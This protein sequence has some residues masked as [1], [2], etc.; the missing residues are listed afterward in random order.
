MIS[1]IVMVSAARFTEVLHFSR[2]R[3]RMA[4]ISVPA[5]PIPTQ[6]TKFVMSKPQPTVLFSPHTP[7]PSINVY[8][9][10]T[11]PSSNIEEE[12]AKASHQ[13]LPALRFRIEVISSLT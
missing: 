1:K 7:I 11:T 13:P 5:C 4:E 9:T 2:N 12:R 6:K 3:N 10:A 8:K